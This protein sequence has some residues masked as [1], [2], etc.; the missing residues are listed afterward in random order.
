MIG[1]SMVVCIP[2]STGAARDA[3]EVLVP[4]VFHAFSMMKGEGH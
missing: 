4:A 1:G 3:L 2:G